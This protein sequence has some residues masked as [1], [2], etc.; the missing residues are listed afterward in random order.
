MDI[1][2]KSNSIPY[3]C[4][5]HGKSNRNHV[6]VSIPQNLLSFSIIGRSKSQTRSMFRC[7]ITQSIWIR[8]PP[9]NDKTWMCAIQQIVNRSWIFHF[10]LHASNF[11]DDHI[12]PFPWYVR[13]RTSIHISFDV[14]IP[15][16]RG[17]FMPDTS[18]SP[19]RHPVVRTYVWCDTSSCRHIS[20]YKAW[21]DMF[22]ACG[23]PAANVIAVKTELSPEQGEGT[24][25]YLPDPYSKKFGTP[26]V[27]GW[28]GGCMHA[29]FSFLSGCYYY[30]GP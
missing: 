27:G 22:S 1:K 29:A 18:P 14:M 9:L 24:L 20:N 10:L 4:P 19:L 13:T 21:E 7:L 8:Y 6:E 28:V 17:S 26:N 2:Q 11:S 12:W 30:G 23:I 16:P 15:L 3:L 25:Q 5:I